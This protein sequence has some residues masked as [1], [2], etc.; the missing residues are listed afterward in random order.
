MYLF[1][2]INDHIWLFLSVSNGNMN[3]SVND[4][5]HFVFFSFDKNVHTGYVRNVVHQSAIVFRRPADDMMILK[6]PCANIS[7]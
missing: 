6:Q 3:R 4:Y 2:Q 5:H 1:I 7:L